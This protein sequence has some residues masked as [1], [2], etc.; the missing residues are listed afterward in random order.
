MKL[1]RIPEDFIVEEKLDIPLLESGK[2]WVYTLSKSGIDTHTAVQLICKANKVASDAVGVCGRKDKHAK[3]IQYISVPKELKAL[4][5]RSYTLKHVGFL[6]SPLSVGSHSANSFT[7]TVRQIPNGKAAQAYTRAQSLLSLAVPNYYDSQ[8]FGSYIDGTFVGKLVIAGEYEQAVKLLLTV[9][10]PHEPAAIR[11]EKRMLSSRWKQ[12]DVV[13]RLNHVMLRKPYLV[14]LRDGWKAAYNAFAYH[15]KVLHMQA[16]QSYLWNQVLNSLVREKKYFVVKYAV[17]SLSFPLEKISLPSQI[18][19]MISSF[20]HPCVAAILEKEGL[21]DFHLQQLAGKDVTA[22][23]DAAIALTDVVVSKPVA[24]DLAKK[25]E[26]FSKL[27]VSFTL[28]VG[29][30]ATVVMKAI[31]RQ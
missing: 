16:Y 29:S 14:G 3:T 31:L 18:P 30:Y 5:D 8:R 15:E 24:D 28:P 17:G 21:V 10:S 25:P 27:T 6:D 9:S 22:V 23:R 7:I 1:K 2:Y 26:Q 19:L 20:S 13:E 4:S 11:A 12:K